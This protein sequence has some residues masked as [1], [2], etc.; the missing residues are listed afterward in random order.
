MNIFQRIERRSDKTKGFAKN[1]KF[2]QKIKS[3]LK[4][5]QKKLAPFLIDEKKIY[6]LDVFENLI[7]KE[8]KE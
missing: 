4:N 2:F 8:I 1:K 7:L 6:Y 3:N 5:F